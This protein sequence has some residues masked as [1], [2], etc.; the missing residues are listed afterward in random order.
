MDIDLAPLKTFAASRP[1]MYGAPAAAVFGV[2]LGLLLRV[3]AQMEPPASMEPRD[4]GVAE[5]T[6]EPIAWPAGKVPDYVIGTDFLAAAHPR[7]PPPSDYAYEP[8]VTVM[9]PAEAAPPPVVVAA[10]PAR[11]ARDETRWASTSG[12][13]L[14]LRLPD[15]APEA[16][17]TL[18]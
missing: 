12:D 2:V 14:D 7:S 1:V 13:I 10:R 9:E 17:P 8:R 16:P 15:D 4:G 3:G 5:Q 11:P 6:A 18:N